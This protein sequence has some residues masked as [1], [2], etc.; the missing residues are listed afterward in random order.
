[1][2]QE[3]FDTDEAA[4]YLKLSAGTLK[5]WRQTGKGPRF[6][7]MSYQIVR[8]ERSALDDFLAAH[9]VDGRTGVRHNL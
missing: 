5:R 4:A 6:I 7:R 3:I 9:T 1:M 2:G 8:Y